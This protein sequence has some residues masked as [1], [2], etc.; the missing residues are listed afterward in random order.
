VLWS[1]P[2]ALYQ[3]EPASL[4]RGR[5]LAREPSVGATSP[6]TASSPA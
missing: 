6:G 4:G 1:T 3:V 2:C 5:A